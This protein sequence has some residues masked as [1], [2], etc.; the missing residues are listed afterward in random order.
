MAST[1]PEANPVP[2]VEDSFEVN[3]R[4]WDELAELHEPS[5]GYDLARFAVD[6]E[7]LSE[8]VRFD[9]PRLGDLT[10]LDAVHLQCHIGSD[11][12][13]LARLGAR[14]TGLDF[15]PTAIGAARRLA[16]A[17][18]LDVEFVEANTYDAVEALGGERFDLVYTGVGALCWLPRIDRWAAVVARLLR[19]GGR[20]FL[21]EGH[22][23]LWTLD[24]RVEDRL[25]IAFPY[26][27]HDEPLAWDDDTSYVE[28]SRPLQQTVSHSWNHGL[29][30]IVTALL[31]AGL[32][33]TMLVEHDSA[34]WDPLPGRTAALAGGEFRLADRPRRLAMSYTLQAVKPPAP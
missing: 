1:P 30:E 27:E 34:P 25:E 17:C 15:S 3:R 23:M 28:V 22:P 4:V 21:R 29:G 7:H 13:S 19:P 10:G 2:S 33:L 5:P 24:E 8:V 14:L 18:G 6:P 31:D 26:F 16:S 32:Q 12:I 20:L 9:L 11:T